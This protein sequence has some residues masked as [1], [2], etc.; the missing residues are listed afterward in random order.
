MI[1][2]YILRYL[3]MMDLLGPKVHISLVTFFRNQYSDLGF[4]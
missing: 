1:V 4:H 3:V 2:H